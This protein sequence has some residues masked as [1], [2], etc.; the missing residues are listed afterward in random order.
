MVCA[1]GSAAWRPLAELTDVDFAVSLGNKLM[2]QVNVVRA[3]L[4]PGVVRDGGSITVTS[5]VLAQQPM[6]GGRGGGAGQRR[7][8]GI[9]TGGRARGAARIRINC[10]SPG[11][12]AE[13]LA[14]QG[15]FA[16]G[17]GRGRWPAYVSSVG[18]TATG[19]V[20]APPGR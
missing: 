12:V 18:G 10:V 9:R 13:T 19:I 1:A 15:R 5:G 11:W 3:G 4:S 20:L 8:R 14:G 7:A 16:G 6:A 17:T 2:G